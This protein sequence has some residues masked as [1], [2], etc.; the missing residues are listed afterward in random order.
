MRV[1]SA[2]KFPEI[3]VKMEQL[4]KC[5]MCVDVHLNRVSLVS[6]CLLHVFA[7]TSVLM[8]R[9]PLQNSCRR[10]SSTWCKRV[11][12]V[13]SK[14]SNEFF[15]WLRCKGRSTTTLERIRF[16]PAQPL[17]NLTA[18]VHLLNST[19][20]Q[21]KCS[22][23]RQEKTTHRKNMTS[24]KMSRMKPVNATTFPRVQVTNVTRCDSAGLTQN[25]D[26][27]FFF[28]RVEPPFVQEMHRSACAGFERVS[29]MKNQTTN[30]TQTQNTTKQNNQPAKK[31][32]DCVNAR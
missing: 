9:M 29:C 1:L 17:Q 28:A 18:C 24:M 12:R 32:G 16:S 23:D 15:R 13:A 14:L 27:T 6:I 8:K 2:P 26:G 25:F 22:S 5:Y 20:I 30:T 10:T 4:V 19:F 3:R 21:P 7:P 11:A 31:A